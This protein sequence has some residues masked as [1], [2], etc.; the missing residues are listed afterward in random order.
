MDYVSSDE[1]DVYM[2]SKSEDEEITDL[3]DLRLDLDRFQQVPIMRAFEN[4]GGHCPGGA[5][6]QC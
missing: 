3:R 2:K 4:V 6:E 5:K 1:E